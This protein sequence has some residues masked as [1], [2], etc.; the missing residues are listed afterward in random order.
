MKLNLKAKLIG[1]FVCVIALTVAGGTV[2]Y[3]G[4]GRLD[5]AASTVLQRAN[6]A[7]VAS[8]SNYWAVKQY[9]TQADL[10]TNHDVGLVEEFD[11]NAATMD[12]CRDEL[13]NL[14]TPKRSR[15]ARSS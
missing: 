8:E 5:Q 3:W 6:D 1:G 14:S 2:A 15:L 9:Q 10:V 11:G 7:Q 4:M 12:E 13:D